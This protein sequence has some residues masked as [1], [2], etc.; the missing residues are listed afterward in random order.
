MATDLAEFMGAAIGLNLLFG[1]ALFPAALLTGVAAFGDPRPSGPRL[2]ALE[3][4]IA[5]LI[6]VIVVAFALQVVMADPRSGATSSTGFVPGFEGT[7]SVLLAVGHPRRD[8]DAARDLPPLRPHAAPHRR[9]RPRRRSAA[10]SASSSS[11]SSSPW[12]SPADQHE[13]ARHRR[14]RVPRRRPDRRR[15]Q[16][17]SGLRHAR[18]R[19]SGD[20]AVDRS[21]A[22]PCSRPGS[23]RRAWARWP[24][25][26]SCRGSSTAAS[27]CSCGASS[28]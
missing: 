8:G 10:S 3:A 26:S 25:R 2:P 28:R 24:A 18:V 6:G 16:P 12:A 27:R 4:V 5:G 20:S 14:V 7:E 13:H 22:S 15:R 21:S 19:S 17:D 11:M 1:I 23:R 9:A